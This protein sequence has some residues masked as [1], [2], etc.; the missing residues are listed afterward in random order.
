MRLRKR[1]RYTVSAARQA[2]LFDQREG[3]DP[4]QMI[5]RQLAMAKP[6]EV[7]WLMLLRDDENQLRAMEMLQLS[8]S[9]FWTRIAVVLAALSFPI[10][11]TALAVSM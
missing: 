8:K 10:S 9:V 11:A 6:F 7:A 4:Y 3:E 1:S 2:S 5:A